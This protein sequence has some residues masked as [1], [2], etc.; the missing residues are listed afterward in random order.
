[1]QGH[2]IIVIGASA[3][4]VQTLKELVQELPEHL[5]ASLFIVLHTANQGGDSLLPAILE[6]K[7]PLPAQAP[8]DKT[9]FEKGRIYVARP[10]HHMLIER[11]VIRIVRGPKENRHRPS[12]DPLFRSAAW[13][14][15]PRVVGVVLS[16]T[17]DDGAAGLWAIKTCG[18]V[19]VVQ[20]PAEAPYSGMPTSALMTLRVDYCLPVKRIAMLLGE[21]AHRSV[22]GS[23]PPQGI[24][25][26][27]TETKFATLDRDMEDMEQ[28]N[29]D[30][31]VFSC[32]T[33]QG[34]LWE[35]KDGEDMLRYRCHVGHAF[36]M[37]SLLAEQTDYAEKAIYSALR[38]L[39]EKAKALRRIAE[40]FESRFPDIHARYQQEA[41]QLDES[42]E[43]IRQ[44][45]ASR[46]V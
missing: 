43:V 4:G 45:L 27:K 26:L 36:S 46:P 9:P 38:A 6:R 17:L 30:P 35:L 11:D 20:D 39:Q 37:D 32:P 8:V 24:D 23:G 31:S 5:P 19:T 7:G 12:V 3:G 14:H 15:G 1:M 13:S 40:R 10:D 28:L 41:G 18:G 21:L 44:L 29:G 33:C 25:R 42:A 2:D 22:K 34:T 16:G